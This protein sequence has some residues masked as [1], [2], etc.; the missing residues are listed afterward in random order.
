MIDGKSSLAAKKGDDSALMSF[1]T[2]LGRP[3]GSKCEW[4]RM[5]YL[6]EEG[7]VIFFSTNKVYR[8]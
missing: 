7:W 1:Q 8:S 4:D 6:M 2:S 3:A 5:R